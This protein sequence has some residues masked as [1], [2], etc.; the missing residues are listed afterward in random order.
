[1]NIDLNQIIEELSISDIDVPNNLW[2]KKIIE[3]IQEI[4]K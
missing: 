4:K 1:M 2:S 3:E